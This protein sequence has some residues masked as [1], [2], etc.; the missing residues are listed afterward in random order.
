[1]FCVITP[2]GEYDGPVAPGMLALHPEPLFDCH[3]YD[4]V[5]PGVFRVPSVIEV[6]VT[7]F[8]EHT[9]MREGI[10]PQLGG[11]AG[12]TLTILLAT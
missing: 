6:I 10:L 8:P 3:A 12:A 4:I 9:G 5:P 7:E 1:M 2:G 11:V